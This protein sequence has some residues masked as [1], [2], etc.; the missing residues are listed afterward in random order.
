M[1]TLT[2]DERRNIL[3]ALALGTGR[4]W[5]HGN[6]CFCESQICDGLVQRGMMVKRVNTRETIYA[7]TDAGIDAAGVG[8]RVRKE[9]RNWWGDDE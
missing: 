7:V 5:S 3:H 9:D 1:D 8:D 2:D 4:R 6:Y